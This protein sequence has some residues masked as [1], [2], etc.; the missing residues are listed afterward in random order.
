MKGMR[1]YGFFDHYDIERVNP[2]RVIERFIKGLDKIHRKLN[3]TDKLERRRSRS[4]AKAVKTNNRNYRERLAQTLMQLRQG[5]SYSQVEQA[6]GI[7]L[8]TVKRHAKVLKG[9][10]KSWVKKA[11]ASVK[12]AGVMSISPPTHVASD[13]AVDDRL[14]KALTVIPPRYYAKLSNWRLRLKSL[15]VPVATWQWFL[16]RIHPSERAEAERMRFDALAW[17]RLLDADRERA[18]VV[19]AYRL[20]REQRNTERNERSE[21]IGSFAWNQDVFG[22]A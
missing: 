18:Q 11:V 1:S 22:A 16:E 8:S 2:E 13:S 9:M 17:Q 6:L 19:E 5:L 15:A 3:R 21:P 20:E 10:G 4:R 7:S 14:D 12:S